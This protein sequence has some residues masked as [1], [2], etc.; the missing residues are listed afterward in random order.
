MSKKKRKGHLVRAVN[1]GNP[2]SKRDKNPVTDVPKTSYA[3]E[4]VPIEI[5]R[6]KS[7]LLK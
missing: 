7:K 2:V 3:Q 4:Q 1:P 6:L 5:R